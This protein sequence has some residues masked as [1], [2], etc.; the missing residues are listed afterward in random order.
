MALLLTV[1]VLC[2]IGACTDGDSLASAASRVSEVSA[3]PSSPPAGSDAAFRQACSDPAVRRH[4]ESLFEAI[5]DGDVDAADAMVVDE[6]RFA[7]F[8]IDPIRMNDDAY[9]RDSLEPFLKRATETGLVIEL[10]D[11]AVAPYRA[12]D[13]TGNFNMELRWGDTDRPIEA[14]I[15]KGAI[16]CATGKLMVLS[17]GTAPPT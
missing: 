15:G 4:L 8:S 13:N 9:D 11:V 10:I 7:W 14:R 17:I 6:P 5:T 1:L 3:P 12:A 2:S 16:D